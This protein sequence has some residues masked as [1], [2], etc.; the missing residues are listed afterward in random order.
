MKEKV[1]D[2]LIPRL[3][4]ITAKYS[5]LSVRYEYN[6]KRRVYLVSYD[7][8]RKSEDPGFIRSSIELEEQMNAFFGDEAP[9]FCDNEEL[10]HLSPNATQIPTIAKSFSSDPLQ[11]TSWN[12]E[13]EETMSLGMEYT[14]A[15]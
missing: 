3:E 15:A 11:N 6:E 4:E 2:T 9:L 8:A 14:L 13:I 7:Y 1:L 10:F 5:W 12:T